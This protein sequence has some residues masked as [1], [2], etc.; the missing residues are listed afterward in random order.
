MTLM[1]LLTGVQSMVVTPVMAKGAV[2]VTEAG[3]TV[4]VNVVLA[5]RLP[6]SVAVTVTLDTPDILGVPDI[7]RVAGLK[8]KP[9]VGLILA[10]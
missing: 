5:D 4:M 7:I 1:R 10:V 3:L 6:G 9:F 8:L 2:L